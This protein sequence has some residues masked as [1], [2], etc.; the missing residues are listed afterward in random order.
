MM[1]KIGEK[2]TQSCINTFLLS[3]VYASIAG[4]CCQGRDGCFGPVIRHQL[5]RRFLHKR[6]M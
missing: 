3:I 1:K 5:R 2:F 4:R 6:S